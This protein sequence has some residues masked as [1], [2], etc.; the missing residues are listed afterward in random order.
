MR[1]FSL[2]FLLVGLLAGA[3][4]SQ[5]EI[6][7]DNDTPQF[8][9]ITTGSI[10]WTYKSVPEAVGGSV[11]YKARGTGANSV[12]W[13]TGLTWPG[14]YSIDMHVINGNYPDSV[15]CTIHTLDKDT[16]VIVNQR[17]LTGWQPLGTFTLGDTVWIAMP[18]KAAGK[19]NLILAD[20]IRLRSDMAT[21]PV[22][23]EVRFEDGNDQIT[24]RVNF[25]TLHSPDVLL[26]WIL[27]PDDRTFTIPEAV[28]G[29]YRLSC[30]A[31]GY[32]TAIIDSFCVAG[33]AVT[34]LELLMKPSPGLRY[35]IRGTLAL[36]DSA[37]A[38]QVRVTAFAAGNPLPVALD[39]A[40]HGG[41]YTLANLIPGEYQLLFE[42]P[43]YLTDKSTFARVSI[44]N[45]DIL[46][47]S[48]KMYR[49]FKF[50]WIT[51][52]HIG[53]GTDN[54]LFQIVDRIN[55][56]K[57]ELDFVIHSGDITEK[58]FESELN[59][60]K[61]LINR[62][63]IPIYH[64]PGNHESKWSPTAMSAYVKVLG[65]MH[66]SFSHLGFKFIGVNNAI[67]MRGGCGFFDPADF[68][69]LDAELD[70]LDFENQPLVFICHLP[71]D[72]GGAPNYWQVLDRLKR[73]RTV[74]IMVGHGHTNRAY[75]F[76]SL[77]GAMGRDT[78]SNDP[79]FNIVTLSEKEILAETC[80]AATGN[81]AAA[82]Y[83]KATPQ[84]IQPAIEFVNLQA[85]EKISGTRT[86]EIHTSAAVG[87]GQW[88]ITSASNGIQNLSGSGQDWQAEVAT[89]ELRNGYHTLQVRFVS[90]A[91]QTISSTCAFYVDNG[92]PGAQW[93]YNCA[94]QVLT[95][96]A[97]DT[98][99][100]YVGTTDGR[101]IA[102][103]LADGQPL[104]PAI[105]T[106]GAIASSPLLHGGRLYSG[107]ADGKLYAIDTATGAVAWTFQAQGS[108]LTAPVIADTLIYFAGGNT[109]YALGLSNRQ[110]LWSTAVGTVECKP[111]IH[112]DKIIFGSWDGYVRALNRFTG[113]QLW[114]WVRN[115]N[116]YYAP[117]ACWPVATTDKVF[118]TDPERYMS[119]IDLQTGK[120]V[121]SSKTPEFYDSVGLSTD[122]A[123]VYGRS[124]NGSLYAF[125]AASSTQTPLWSTNLVYGF[126]TIASMPV[127]V[128]GRVFSAGKKGFVSAVDGATGASYWQYNVGASHVPTVTPLDRDRVLVTSLSGLLI[129]VQGDPATSVQT[130][131]PGTALPQESRLDAPYPNPFNAVT[132]LPF[133]LH[134]T[135]AVK[136]DVYNIRGEW[137]ANVLD[138]TLAA[139]NHDITWQAEHQASGVYFVRMQAHDVMRQ[140]KVVLVR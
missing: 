61:N 108:I 28:D 134:K 100:V 126:D 74:W 92:Y 140:K 57:E 125:D 4:I 90:A 37:P 95:K 82:W 68:A 5:I 51:D 23:G 112:G 85:Y 12:K 111:L 122:G 59:Q 41:T 138:R 121:W 78:Y 30:S 40:G 98:A 83:R 20:A 39:S 64:V 130:P 34:G 127:E 53:A 107:S 118:V 123:R 76:E 16:V 131:P 132:R 136:M 69:W 79:G 11:R 35:A 63:Q 73:H 27:T 66:F 1:N 116:F 97:C 71:I 33:G 103:A 17:Y 89:T 99:G 26:S 38:P 18:D 120:T 2:V 119:A 135:G 67:P 44:T 114:A 46:L 19:G 48:L 124:L 93:I 109:F 77:P 65:E 14:L 129:L 137:V 62:L 80:T 94:A 133:T 72:V 9:M 49:Y 31:H 70:G 7:L 128:E 117:A 54:A 8:A 84:T 110:T 21:Y 15:F 43:G 22:S 86:L 42:E 45:Q 58:G 88:E 75:D 60:Y 55:L 104:W 13:F 56:L 29:C 96:P 24:C 102:V 87:N 101:I 6:I 105:Q 47:Q 25:Y 10:T 115:T 32:D 106:G 3:S 36:S 139:G 50:A 81:I 113:T 52:S 91:G